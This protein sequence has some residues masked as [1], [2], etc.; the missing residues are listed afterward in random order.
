[1]PK[2]N[3]KASIIVIPVE[4]KN[5]GFTIYPNLALD[6][7]VT[8]TMISWELSER[9]GFKPKRIPKTIVFNTASGEVRAPSGRAVIKT[10][11]MGLHLQNCLPKKQKYFNIQM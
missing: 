11:I 9:L 3:P 7:G 6:T 5:A 10:P 1:M 8:Y 4:L 2:F